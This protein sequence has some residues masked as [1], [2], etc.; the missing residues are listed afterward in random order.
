M[1][2]LQLTE[3][4]YAEHQARVR[5]GRKGLALDAIEHAGVDRVAAESIAPPRPQRKLIR[6]DKGP[7]KIEA[8]FADE[9][10]YLRKVRG[11]ILRYEFEAVRL[12]LASGLKYTPDWCTWQSGDNY[13][14]FY[15]IKGEK[16]NGRVYARDDAVAK[17]KSAA[18]EYPMW[19]FFLV[20]RDEVT[21]EWQEQKVIA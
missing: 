11:E 17:I 21:K 13:L 7:N 20:W 19:G 9:V 6:Q 10:L 4:M 12:K 3:E 2:S 16:R 8:A 1:K 18:R 5:A 15:E 14:R